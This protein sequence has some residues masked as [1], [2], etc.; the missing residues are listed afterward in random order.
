MVVNKS[1]GSP[2]LA[3]VSHE[4]IKYTGTGTTYADKWK[5]NPNTPVYLN[6]ATSTVDEALKGQKPALGYILSKETTTGDMGN[7]RPIKLSCRFLTL[8]LNPYAHSWIV[9]RNN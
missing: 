9:A 5:V 7:P 2:S 6:S 1:D 4:N 3:D 8:R